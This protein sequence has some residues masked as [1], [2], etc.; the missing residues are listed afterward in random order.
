MS[1]NNIELKD[2]L[3]GEL[4]RNHLLATE[5]KPAATPPSAPSAT[6]SVTPPAF[7]A[8]AP[9]PPMIQMPTGHLSPPAA[10]V[11]A[12]P[13][14]PPPT[15]ATVPPPPAAGA[16]PTP[17][18]KTPAQPAEGFYRTL[19]NHRRKITILVNTPGIAFLPDDQ[20]A[21]LTKMLEACKMNIGDVAI[22]NHATLPL[23]IAMLKQQLQPS[24]ILLFGLEP[25][26]IRLPLNFPLFK[27]QNYDQ[28]TYLS[29]SSLEEL[30]RPGEENKLLKSKLW[31]SLKTLFGI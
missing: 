25:T 24:F 30:I 10:G 28:T 13:I 7:Q 17:A 8:Q 11:P 9:T 31:V 29:S 26:A 1:L 5:G 4:Y 14:P 27:I 15:T 2:I 3:I 12:A 23:D 18:A 6:T 16:P 22:I 20:L 21:F 19:G